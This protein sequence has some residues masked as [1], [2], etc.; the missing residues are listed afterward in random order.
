MTYDTTE[1]I[2]QRI[3]QRLVA[4]E[5]FYGASMLVHHLAS[6]P[7]ALTGSDY[8][9]DD[10]LAICVRDDYQ[11]AWEESGAMVAWDSQGDAYAIAADDAK[12]VQGVYS[13]FAELPTT[14]QSE[15]DSVADY[16]DHLLAEFGE[17][18]E[19]DAEPSTPITSAD[20]FRVLCE[21]AGI[22]PYQREA[23]EHWIVSNWLAERLAECGEMTG[24]LL[25]FTLWG[26]TTTGQAIYLDGVIRELAAQMEI[27]AGQRFAWEGGA[28]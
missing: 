11:S 16:R 10:V 26:R 24:E 22:E 9:Y 27:L 1:T 25:G 8:T 2:N 7:E 17:P 13:E 18:V 21:S 23:Y 14:A 12:R 6:N 5:V 28:K 20:D 19:L 3:C 15:F 4:R